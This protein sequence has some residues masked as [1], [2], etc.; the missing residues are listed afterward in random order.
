MSIVPLIL[1]FMTTL[2]LYYIINQ[3]CCSHG[4]Y[5]SLIPENKKHM[6]LLKQDSALELSAFSSSVPQRL[7]TCSANGQQHTND[8][9]NAPPSVATAAT[10]PMISVPVGSVPVIPVKTN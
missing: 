3:K 2:S 7:L 10:F 6:L 5:Y 4:D 8:P 1:L 9:Y